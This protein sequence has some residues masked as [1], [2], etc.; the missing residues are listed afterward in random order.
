MSSTLIFPGETTP[1]SDPQE[2][3]ERLEHDVDLVLDG[4]YC[5]LEPTTVLAL[6][7][8]RVTLLRQ[9]RGSLA[10]FPGMSAHS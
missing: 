3:R 8:G 9:G 7:D 1:P 2:I 5:G 6:D 10:P 4:G